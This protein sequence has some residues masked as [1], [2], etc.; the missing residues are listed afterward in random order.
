MIV[1]NKKIILAFAIFFFSFHARG[2]TLPKVFGNNMVLQQNDSVHFWGWAGGWKTKLLV[3]TSWG[4]ADTIMINSGGNWSVKIQTPPASF[5]KQTVTFQ[6]MSVG[7]NG[8]LTP[9]EGENSKIELSNV[10]IGEVWLCSGQSNMQLTSALIQGS[11][12]EIPKANHPNI[13]FFKIEHRISDYPQD[14]IGGGE[15]KECTPET[16]K[17]FSAVGYFFGRRIY[18]K[19]NVPI[20]LITDAWGGTPIEVDYSTES[21]NNKPRLYESSQKTGNFSGGAPHR[22]GSVYNAMTYPLRDF[23]IAGML[24][25]QGESNVK[26]DADLYAKKL[27]NLVSERR[28]QFGSELPFYYVQ[29]APYMHVKKNSTVIIRDQQRI[30]TKIP[31]AEMV[32]ISDIGDTT[33]IHPKRKIEVGERLANVALK[34]HYHVIDNLVLSPLFKDACLVGNDVLVDFTHAEGLH[35]GEGDKGYFEVAGATGKFEKVKAKVVGNKISLDVRKIENPQKVRFAWRNTAT[36]L[37]FNMAGLPA[38]CFG[39]QAIKRDR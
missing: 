35:F 6:E 13:R 37:L 8:T 12:T 23:A 36:P 20:G 18:E 39:E 24:W 14:D 34:Y 17:A 9:K 15:W 11:E 2:V 5:D 25:Y 38:S 28:K 3:T 29:I 27:E 19:L 33:Y 31:N 7:R 32:V 26:V 1:I 4:V 10:L 16:M 22:L 21:L 30:A